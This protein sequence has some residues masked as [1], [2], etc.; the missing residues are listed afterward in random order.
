MKICT[1][2]RLTGDEAEVMADA[3][4]FKTEDGRTAFEVCIGKDGRSLEIRA[5]EPI[6][7]NGTIYGTQLLVVPRVSNSVR[8]AT[9]EY[10]A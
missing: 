3:V 10:D 1:G 2:H 9:E 5:V 6:K 4:R 8:V 7:A